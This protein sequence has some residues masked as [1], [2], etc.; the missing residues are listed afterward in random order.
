[1]L[2][3]GEPYRALICYDNLSVNEDITY[4]LGDIEN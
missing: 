3:L 2:E 1:M 4:T